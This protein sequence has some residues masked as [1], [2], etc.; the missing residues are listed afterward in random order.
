MLAPQPQDPCPAAESALPRVVAKYRID[1]ALQKPD[2]PK[3]AHFTI[4]AVWAMWDPMPQDFMQHIDLQLAKP[5]NCS[6]GLPTTLQGS[7]TAQHNSIFEIS[8]FSTGSASPL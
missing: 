4:S 3:P 5:F 2:A 7:R 6:T 1:L 8:P